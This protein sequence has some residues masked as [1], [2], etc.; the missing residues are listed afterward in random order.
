[1]DTATIIV[2]VVVAGIVFGPGLLEWFRKFLERMYR[3]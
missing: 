3:S 1:M 2:I